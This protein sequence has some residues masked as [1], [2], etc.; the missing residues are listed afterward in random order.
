MAIGGPL[1][2]SGKGK[3][4]RGEGGGGEGRRAKTGRWRGARIQVGFAAS[5]RMR[6]LYLDPEGAGTEGGKEREEGGGGR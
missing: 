3:E 1:T 5:P 6:D 4:E 2:Y